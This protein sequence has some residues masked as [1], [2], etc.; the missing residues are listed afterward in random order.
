MKEERIEEN[1][2][3][4][5]D[6]RGIINDYEFFD[7]IEYKDSN[8]GVFLPLEDNQK[9]VVLKQGDKTKD[10]KNIMY[11]P[12]EDNNTLIEILN[13][14]KEKYKEDFDFE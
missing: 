8:Y 5:K 1:I 14:I 3:K 10:N 2:V 6:D 12:V 11:T 7:I 9:I 13:I 4:L